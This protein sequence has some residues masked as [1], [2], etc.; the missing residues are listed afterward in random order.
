MRQTDWS[1]ISQVELPRHNITVVNC[2]DIIRT[3]EITIL[4]ALHRYKLLDDIKLNTKDVKTPF[5]YHITQALCEYV[6][7]HN[8][9]NVVFYYSTCDIRFMELHEYIEAH[10][11][12]Q[13]ISTIFKHVSSMFPMT[14]Y[15]GTECFEMFNDLN[16]G[17]TIDLI[18]SIKSV[19][20]KKRFESLEKIKK[21]IDTYKLKHVYEKYFLH[22]KDVVKFY[23]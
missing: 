23:K 7:E 17:D 6:T 4:N 8:R 12:K 5:Y 22:N 21:F 18:E 9:D 3:V 16:C 19:K 11:L 14:F 13:F 2:C 1:K 15:Y 20:R 10:R